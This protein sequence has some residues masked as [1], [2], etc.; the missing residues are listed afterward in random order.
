VS[1]TADGT[2]LAPCQPGASTPTVGRSI[3]TRALAISAALA[4]ALLLAGCT[5]RDQ[6]TPDARSSLPAGHPQRPPPARYEV[7]AS[8]TGLSPAETRPVRLWGL[9]LLPRGPLL[10]A[11]GASA[12]GR[13]AIAALADTKE[14][15]PANLAQLER[16][17]DQLVRSEVTAVAVLGGL[18]PAF[19]GIRELLGRLKGVAPVLA[20]PGDR[21]SKSG[22]VAAAAAHAPQVVDLTKVRAIATPIASLIAVPGYHL[23]HHLL[24]REQG[25][26]YGER[27][28]EALIGLAHQLPQPRLLLAHGPPRG[29]GPR[30]VDRSFGEV[31]IGDPLL[32]RL[33]EQGEIPFGLF[34]HVHEATGQATTLQGSPVPEMTWSESLLLNVGSADAVPHEDLRGRWS[35]GS[36]AIVEI[37]GS[38]ARY[39]MIQLA[40]GPLATDEP[41][42]GAPVGG[43]FDPTDPLR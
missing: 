5:Q 3:L 39:R 34:A 41:R 29:E 37:E 31:N 8:L 43:R 20:L 13:V 23:P 16:L 32:R 9:R 26:S 14:A 12:P 4:L 40:G 11:E 38:R 35:R 2:L 15:S 28:I 19:E 42:S 7:C 21:E 18:D 1:R 24:A 30:A 6:G 27:E 17:A 22:F 10:E 25:C 33:M 36:A